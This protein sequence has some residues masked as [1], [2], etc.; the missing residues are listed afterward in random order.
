MLAGIDE[1]RQRMDRP[2]NQSKMA[3]QRQR[4]EATRDEL[5]KAAEAADQGS[6]GKAVASGTRAQRQLE[7]MRDDLRKESASQ[8][9]EELRQLRQDARELARKQ[10]EVRRTMESA[11]SPSGPKSLTE[12]PERREAAEQ[13]ARQRS[14]L[15]NLI[16][17]ATEVSQKA[18][19]AEPLVS[20][21]LYDT[22]RKFQQEDSGTVK[23]LQQELAERGQLTQKLYDHLQET[24]GQGG[25]T[26]EMAA[27]LLRQGGL[28]QADRVE[29]RARG[30]ISQFRDGVEQAAESVLGD[31]TE[32][33]RRAAGELDAL[34]SE[35]QREM[36][37]DS[38]ENPDHTGA[39]TPGAEA[40]RRTGAS[41]GERP[42]QN[43]D[44]REPGNDGSQQSSN[45]PRRPGQNGSPGEEPASQPGRQSGQGSQS[46]PN[47]PQETAASTPPSRSPGSPAAGPR[48]LQARTPGGANRGNAGTRARVNLQDLAGGG[49]EGETT[50]GEPGGPG[51]LT[52]GNFA[53]WSDRLREVEEV[54]DSPELRAGVAGAR[55]RAR[56]MRLEYRRDL[57]KPDWATVRLEVL[58]PLVEVRQQIAEELARRGSRDALV[59]IDRDPVPTRYTELVR[60]Y[61]EEL[62]K[63]H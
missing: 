20:Q 40:A 54:V 36:A 26:L 58:K 57:K 11:A 5:Q 47:A 39:S 38:G 34:T 22:L 41:P 56:L 13:L 60:K 33:L 25:Q 31:D 4:L 23:K 14:T 59:P 44:A 48:A 27:E 52:G 24:S 62:G 10:D 6:T 51:P 53:P 42:D 32:A 43:P 1:L 2:E 15:T 49:N 3:E 55:E 37:R 29:Q 7:E 61:Y 12:S 21:K 46:T 63:D 8:F 9:S 28:A 50:R 19:G 45:S 16:Q 30:G 35:L 17:R 18:E